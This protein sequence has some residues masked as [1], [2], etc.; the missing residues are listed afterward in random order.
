[1]P[2]FNH[3]TS[4]HHFP[5][6]ASRRCRHLPLPRGPLGSHGLLPPPSRSHGPNSPSHAQ[7][8][9]LYRCLDHSPPHLPA[10]GLQHRIYRGTVRPYTRPILRMMILFPLAQRCGASWNTRATRVLIGSTAGAGFAIFCCR[11]LW[12]AKWY[13][14]RLLL[15]SSLFTT[16]ICIR[17]HPPSTRLFITFVY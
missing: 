16:C 6:R 5:P 11:C 3:P 12:L 7:Q 17:S 15:S 9:Y 1:M 10:V 2:L 13:A 4:F 14:Y 8:M